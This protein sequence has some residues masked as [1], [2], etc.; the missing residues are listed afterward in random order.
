M[1]VKMN[2][3]GNDKDI[4]ANSAGKREETINMKLTIAVVL[5]QPDDSVLDNILSYI[6]LTERLYVIDNSVSPVSIIDKLK[7]Y[8]QVTYISMGGNKG[9]ASAL[10]AGIFQAMQE[11][12]THLMTM[13]QDSR[14]QQSVFM[15]YI[16][17]ADD[18]FNATQ[19]AAIVGIN[20]D[21]YKQK[22]QKA[23]VEVVEEVI[24][25]GMIINLDIMKKLGSFIEKL[26]IDYVDYEYCYRARKAGY[27]CFIVNQYRLEHQIGGMN[28]IVKY[29]IHFRNHNE[30]NAI[31]QYYMARN[32]IY[33]M[34]N[35]PDMAMKWVKN[36]I[37]SPIKILLVDDD[38]G[39]KF[40]GYI[41]GIFD[42]IRGQYG[43]K[44]SL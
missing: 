29:G 35:Y 5:Y 42:G 24:T 38:K 16:Q 14:F 30:H 1:K 9:I 43:P 37:K 26:F 23:D 44:T 22:N 11:N 28:P 20:Y 25:S 41:S 12:F 4:T 21:G 17:K 13:D 33:V 15:G 18:I 7:K 36:L 19:N 27:L 2:E 8:P 32:A 6:N 31:R 3:P 40:R 34:I 10:N 39:K